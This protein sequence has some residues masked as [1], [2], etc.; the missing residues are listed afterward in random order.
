MSG[1]MPSL[2]LLV[3]RLGMLSLGSSGPDFA[4]PLLPAPCALQ[5]MALFI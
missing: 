4:P 2:I 1:R 5:C 3:L